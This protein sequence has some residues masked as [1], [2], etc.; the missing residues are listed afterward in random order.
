M[1]KLLALLLTIAALVKALI[2]TNFLQSA[3]IP[4][5]IV[6]IFLSFGVYCFYKNLNEER[7]SES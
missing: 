3:T 1:N 4:D 2:I 5:L 6:I 7:I